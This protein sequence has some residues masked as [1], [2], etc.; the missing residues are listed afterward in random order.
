VTMHRYAPGDNMWNDLGFAMLASGVVV[1]ESTKMAVEK[2]VDV[3]VDAA[4][5]ALLEFLGAPWF[6]KK[7]YDA[8]QTADK[9]HEIKENV[10]HGFHK[11]GEYYGNEIMDLRDRYY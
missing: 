6:V 2:T 10:T 1:W 11:K 3:G 8:K 7:L 5:A 9:I 4:K